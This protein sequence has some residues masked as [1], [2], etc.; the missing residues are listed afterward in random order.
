VP[1][2]IGF[3]VNFFGLEAS[4]LFVNNN[5]NVTFEQPLFEFGPFPLTNTVRLIIAPF[6]ADVDT[7]NPAS[8]VVTYGNDTVDGRAAF[9]VNWDGVGYDNQHADRLNRFQLVLIERGDTGSGNFDIE[10]KL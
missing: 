4:T 2:P 1:Q 7:R 9:G 5:G 6:F 3:T 8:A 10:F